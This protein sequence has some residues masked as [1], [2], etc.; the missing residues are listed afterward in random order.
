MNKSKIGIA[1]ILGAVILLNGCSSIR[2]TSSLKPA[3]EKPT[4]PAGVKFC[5]VQADAPA[6]ARHPLTDKA[7][8]Q[9]PDI[10]TDEMTGLPILVKEDSSHSDTTPVAAFM[11]GFFTLGAIPFPG[12]D[13]T[14]YSISTSL[15]DATGNLSPVG[16]SGFTFKKSMWMTVTGPLGLLP[17][18]GP[19]DLTRDYQCLFINGTASF[20]KASRKEA[21]YRNSCMLAAIVKTLASADSVQMQTVYRERLNQVQHFTVDGQHCN[22][23]LTMTTTGAPQPGSTYSLIVY[24]GTPS[25]AMKPLDEV[26]VARYDEAGRWQPLTGYLRHARRLTSARA[27]IENGRPAKVVVR[28][29]EFPPLEDF[30]DNPP[31]DQKDSAANLRWSNAMLLDAKNRSLDALLRDENRDSLLTMTTRIEKAILDLSEQAERS[32]DHAQAMVEKDNGDPDIERELAVLCRQRIE[33]LKP[34]LAVIKMGASAQ[35]QKQ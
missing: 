35:P 23:I 34:I 15:A 32:K 22:G 17:I 20:D 25:R 11:T 29:P 3:D 1:I 26:I 5:L 28:N 4:H 14:V 27:L 16:N 33:I 2:Y 7:I 21:D 31:L 19:S 10:F 30:I 9:Y 18:I 13:K 12:T 8:K 6:T 24:T